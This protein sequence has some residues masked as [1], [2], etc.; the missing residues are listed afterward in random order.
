MLSC[1][2]DSVRGSNMCGMGKFPD[3]H[4]LPLRKEWSSSLYHSSCDE[5]GGVERTEVVR[6]GRVSGVRE[7][8]PSWIPTQLCI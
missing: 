2:P 5:V 3:G 8:I 6:K 1:L 7:T 4:Y